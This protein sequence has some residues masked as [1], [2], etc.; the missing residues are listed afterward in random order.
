MPNNLTLRPIYFWALAGA[1]DLV[2]LIFAFLIAGIRARIVRGRHEVGRALEQSRARGRDLA[3]SSPSL[4]FQMT[5]AGTVLFASPASENVLGI[6]ADALLGR[7][8]VAMLEADSGPDIR[9]LLA[10]LIENGRPQLFVARTAEV[11]GPQRVVEGTL[12]LGRTEHVLEIATNW[13]NS[14]I[15]PRTSSRWST[16]V[17]GVPP[18][19][20]ATTWR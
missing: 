4:L 3:N 19:P 6:G 13:S 14:S 15:S 18:R 8:L 20:V 12:Q 16:S 10:T 5:A 9:T 11:N 2:I 1:A 17:A 7:D